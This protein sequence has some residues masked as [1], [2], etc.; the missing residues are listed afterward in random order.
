MEFALRPYVT[1]GVAVAGASLIAAA[2]VGQ[3]ALNIQT[4]AVQLA[5]VDAVADLM[6][7]Q[8]FPVSTWADL[9]TNTLSNLEEIG[10]QIAA[11]PTPILSTIAANQTEYASWLATGAEQSASN[12]VT[13]LQ[14]FSHVV[15]NAITDLSSGD[16]YDADVLIDE[17]LNQTPLSLVR[18]LE[19]AYFEVSQSITNNL[20]NVL[21]DDSYVSPN[22]TADL[23]GVFGGGYIPE[24]FS[25]LQQAI[26]LPGRAAELAFAGVSQDIVNAVQNN[27]DTLAFNDALNLLPTT[28]DAYLNG[29]NLDDA[30]GGFG[31]GGRGGYGG[32]TTPYQATAAEPGT[33]DSS[34][35]LLSENG[36][37]ETVHE[38]SERIAR[39]ISLDRDRDQLAAADASTTAS[40]T[41]DLHTLTA[42]VTS[43]L[44]PD[45]PLGEVASLFD[46]N[47]VPDVTSLL[48]TLF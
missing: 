28:I 48:T 27:N 11:D 13:A 22:A 46:P 3:P 18:P 17:Y 39:E 23:G 6:T 26:L 15:S 8:E 37:V 29:Y 43:L 31:G 40:S 1:V 16:V 21:N 35:G 7:G 25:E 38:V 41:T 44:N 36:T 24:W 45:T 42:D 9:A 32:G 10:S 14:D 12:L 5:S 30:G 34:E 4:R 20:D 33:P 19:N 2:P 47:A